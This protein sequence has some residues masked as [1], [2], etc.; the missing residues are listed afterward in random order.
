MPV[1]WKLAERLVVGRH[2]ALTLGTWISTDGGCPQPREDLALAGRD[3]GVALDQL[4][5]NAPFGL[6]PE[7]QRGDDPQQ[8]VLTSPAST[9]A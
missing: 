6:D 7:R 3:R 8:H 5:H 4:G 2:L 9:P 1:S